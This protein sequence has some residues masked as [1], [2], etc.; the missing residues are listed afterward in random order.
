MS[1]TGGGGF[2][3]EAVPILDPEEGGTPWWVWLLIG[4]GMAVLV[5]LILIWVSA[6]TEPAPEASPAPAVTLSAS[7]SPSPSV[8]PSET[9]SPSPS[10][11]AS[12][13]PSV[14]PSP[15]PTSTEPEPAPSESAAPSPEPTTPPTTFADG[16]VKVG[17]D[18]EAGTYRTTAAVA[19]GR[20]IWLL[21]GA[22]NGDP[23]H[24]LTPEVL[25]GGIP[26]ISFVNGDTFASN[27][28]GTWSKVDPASL[29]DNTKAP[30]KVRPGVWL[31]GED[32]APGQYQS[33]TLASVGPL[34]ACR[35]TVSTS[36]QNNF[37]TVVVRDSALSGI[38]T[39]TLEAGQQIESKNCGTWT[40]LTK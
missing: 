7:P 18:V 5:G 25:A 40:P 31:V 36:L 6:V 9:P 24:N 4:L 11:S 37:T 21:Q 2:E 8:T 1:E 30:V 35:W 15:E 32:V 12:V 22:A 29:F 26:T 17:T 39:V 13:T 33:E 28:C 10:P 38:A 19:A 34:R 27:G 23:A 16:V 20:C 3:T 14:T